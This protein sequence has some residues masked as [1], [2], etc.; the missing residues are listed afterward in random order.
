MDSQ[1]SF[2]I[3]KNASV[4]AQNK[5]AYSL[6]DSYCIYVA[7]I[8]LEKFFKLDLDYSV[9]ESIKKMDYTE[10]FVDP[11]LAYQYLV[12]GVEVGQKAG[13]YVLGESKLIVEALDALFPLF[14]EKVKVQEKELE[15][16][17]EELD[18]LEL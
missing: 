4:V 2:S 14:D 18:N 11:K 15:S 10:S 8:V 7:I 13:A 3:L 12:K 17:I 5:G 16:R 1:K 9:K 6:M